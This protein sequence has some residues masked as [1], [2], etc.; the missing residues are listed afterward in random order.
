MA[1]TAAALQAALG[2]R[3]T[4]PRVEQELAPYGSTLQYWYISGRVAAPGKAKFVSTTAS[5]N[6]ATQ[7][8]AV[9]VALANGNY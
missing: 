6:A 1:V 4:D 9:L 3:L 5:D 2:T 7:A 8:A